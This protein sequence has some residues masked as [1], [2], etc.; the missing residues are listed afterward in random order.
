[1]V[2]ETVPP[3]VEGGRTISYVIRTAIK[4]Y[5]EPPALRADGEV[6]DL[7]VLPGSATGKDS[8]DVF[9][10]NTGERHLETNGTLE[11][12]RPDNSVA[13]KIPLPTLYTLPAARSRARV[14]MPALPP[15][16]Y[17][18]LAL[19]DF[20]GDQIAAAQSEYELVP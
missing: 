7:R 2:V 8:V 17:I 3:R 10:R 9:F 12:R 16:R 13:A 14:A 1:M 5:V 19:L 20:G 4:V 6:A 15:G 11:F 18:L